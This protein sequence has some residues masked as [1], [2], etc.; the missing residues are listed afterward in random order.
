MSG[1]NDKDKF[2]YRVEIQQVGSL[3]AAAFSRASTLTTQQ[4]M[5]VSGETGEPNAETTGI[6]EEI[7]RGQVIEMVGLL[8][9]SLPISFN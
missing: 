4:M 9:L 1:S 6:I 8:S 3:S 5:F 2:K 7:V